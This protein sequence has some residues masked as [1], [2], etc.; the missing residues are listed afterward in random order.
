MSKKNSSTQHKSSS[1]APQVPASLGTKR[2]C[3]HCTTKF[4]DF[5]RS[6]IRCPKCDKIVDPNATIAYR[7]VEPKRANS[8]RLANQ[9]E[10]DGDIVI[11]DNSPLETSDDMDDTDVSREIDLDGDN[12]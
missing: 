2:Q 12:D 9:L 10:E 1:R 7:R 8:S 5:A 4:Y 6:E 3:P 11:E